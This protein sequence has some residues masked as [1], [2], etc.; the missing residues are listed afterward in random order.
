MKRTASIIFVL[1]SAL[2]L[3]AQSKSFHLEGYDY[4]RY[5]VEEI[6]VAPGTSVELTLKTVSEIPKSQMAHNW[7]LLKKETDVESF[8]NQCTQHEENDYL[9]PSLTGRILAHTGMLGGGEEETISFKAPT[10]PGRYVYVC[11]FP[12]HYVAG[13]KGILTVQE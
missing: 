6:T 10:E 2:M 5:S 13:M 11:T 4:M 1:C 12:G 7:V 9:D 8:V 3:H